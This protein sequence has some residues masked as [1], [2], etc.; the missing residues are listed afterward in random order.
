MEGDRKAT[1]A[2]A[3]KPRP[4]NCAG[5]TA[6][7]ASHAPTV[8]WKANTQRGRIALVAGAMVLGLGAVICLYGL[9]PVAGR[10]WTRQCQQQAPKCTAS[11][12][13][14]ATA[15]LSSRAALPGA[16][17]AAPWLPLS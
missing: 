10:D 5:A 7:M 8:H 12:K 16:P 11:V 13:G 6:A 3:Q 9:R 14:K 4:A 1:A 15:M 17:K 2:K